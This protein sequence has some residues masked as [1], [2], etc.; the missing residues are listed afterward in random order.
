MAEGFITRRVGVGG[1]DVSDATALTTDVLSGKTFYAGDENIKTGTIASKGAETFTPSTSNQTIAS[2]QY[3]S[4]TQTILGDA[5]LIAGN[6]KDGI[7]IF[8]VTGNFTGTGAFTATTLPLTW[9]L[10]VGMGY[11]NYS[12]SSDTSSNTTNLVALPTGTKFI[13]LSQVYYNVGF[14]NN[15]SGVVRVGDFRNTYTRFNPCNLSH[16]DIL[17]TGLFIAVPSGANN[18]AIHVHQQFT[19]GGGTIPESRTNFQNMVL[20]AYQ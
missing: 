12:L 2:G 15:T 6:I 1:V 7:N 5:D 20:K 13:E 8:G 10:Q 19:D 3:L 17:G 14:Y 4:G 18:V 16:A 11:P 9:N